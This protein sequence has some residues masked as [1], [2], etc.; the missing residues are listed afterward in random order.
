MGT[1][2]REMLLELEFHLVPKRALSKSGYLMT[3]KLGV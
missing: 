1:A 2:E 3:T